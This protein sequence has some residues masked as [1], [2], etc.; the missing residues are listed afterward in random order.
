MAG[1]GHIDGEL[2]EIFLLQGV[3][4]EYAARFLPPGQV[5]DVDVEALLR[6]VQ[7]TRAAPAQD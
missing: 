1:D 2:F 5:D 7:A 6:Q 4:R 3:W